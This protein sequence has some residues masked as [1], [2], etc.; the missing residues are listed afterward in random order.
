[1]TDYSVYSDE[2]LCSLAGTDSRAEEFLLVKHKELVRYEARNMYIAWGEWDDL[3]QEGMIGLLQAIRDFNPDNGAMF[4]TFAAVCIRGKML[5]AV[6]AANRKKHKA[7]EDYVSLD[8][9]EFQEMDGSSLYGEGRY[10]NPEL[11]VIGREDVGIIKQKIEEKLSSFER[12]VFRE[13]MNGL[14]YKEIA[15]KLGKSPKT[16][17][18][19]FQRIRLKTKEL[20]KQT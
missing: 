9:P 13:Y 12:T 6:T 5:N 4:A 20:L 14:D 15:G 7:M 17:D 18:N 19:A 2:E 10:G 16:I 11:Q 1:M 8:S 3:L